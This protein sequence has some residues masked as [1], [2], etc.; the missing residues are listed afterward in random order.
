MKKI[1]IYISIL[2]A[3]VLVSCSNKAISVKLESIQELTEFISYNTEYELNKNEVFTF[4]ILSSSTYVDDEYI[5][6]GEYL[7][8]EK[9]TY[10]FVFYGW[11][12]NNDKDLITSSTIE[13]SKNTTF[14]PSYDLT[15]KTFNVN[16]Y[17]NGGIITE[18]SNSDNSYILPTPQKENYNFEGWYYNTSLMGNK[19]TEISFNDNNETLYAKYIP[20]VEY[21][22][23]LINNIPDKLSVL[24]ISSIKEIQKLYNQL[25][26]SD[27]VNVQNYNKVVEGDKQ[28]PDLEKAFKVYNLI[29]EISKAEVTLAL[30]YDLEQI[31]A[32]Y[33]SLSEK[34]KTYVTNLE[35]LDPITEEVNRLFE[36]YGAEALAFDLRIAAIPINNEIIYENEILALYDEYF[37]LDE[38]VESLLNAETK[39]FTMYENLNNIKQDTSTI[40]YILS[41][42]NNKNI[43][44]SKQELFK[45]YFTDFYYYILAYHGPQ[46]LEKNGIKNVDDFVKL[47]GDFNGG[48]TSNLYGIGNL[49]SAYMI[50]KDINGILENQNIDSFFGFCYKNDM[51]TDLLPFFIN[52]FAYWRIDEKYANTSNYGAD[53]F[54]EGWAPVV[55]IAKFFYYNEE[56]SYV[57]TERMIDCLTNT[58]SVAYGLE[59]TLP[60]NLKLRGYVFEGWYDNPNFDGNKITNVSLKG[61]KVYLYAKWSVDTNQQ[62]EDFKNLVDIYI[63]NLTTKKAVVNSTTVGYVKNMY[64]KLTKQSQNS[65][66]Y[67]DAYRKLV[68]T[69][70]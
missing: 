37:H 10:T 2:L 47:A 45:C 31:N 65:L 63:Y 70:C 60:T 56:T 55:D 59:G 27:K 4:P 35:L 30:K 34:Q 26:Y 16:L 21:I 24:D 69:Y 54:A 17:T 7:T 39:L 25:P 61:S 8:Y 18:S 57:K 48:G 15:Q 13:V 12:S 43:Y 53:I 33:K 41:T 28:L 29:D 67:L 32:E 50:K 36:L 68:E 40:T 49:T 66:K 9:T 22:N 6:N 20:T 14:T 52:F 51:Y 58:A 5:N 23:Q 42:P 1:I 38:N 11:T 3:F 62:E 64:N 46:H 19:V 44:T